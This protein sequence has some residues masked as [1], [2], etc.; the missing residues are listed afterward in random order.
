MPGRNTIWDGIG[1]I[2]FETTPGYI[3][4]EEIGI[5]ENSGADQGYDGQSK[6]YTQQQETMEQTEVSQEQTGWSVRFSYL[7]LL[8]GILLLVGAVAILM[9][10]R[11]IFRKHLEWMR[12]L[13]PKRGNSCLVWIFCASSET[14]GWS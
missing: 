14:G 13:P 12:A 2:P 4:P 10:R 8:L 6:S 5:D 3:D 1:W 7:I 11:R 9:Y